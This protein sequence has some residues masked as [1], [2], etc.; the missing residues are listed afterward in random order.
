VWRE[1]RTQYNNQHRAASSQGTQS[2]SLRGAESD[3][4]ISDNQGIATLPSV[5]RNDNPIQVASIGSLNGILSSAIVQTIPPPTAADLTSTIEVQFTPAILAKA[6][7]LN[8]NP[9]QIYN[10]V[11]NNIEYTHIRL[12]PGCRHVPTNHAV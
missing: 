1:P 4:A 11:Y 8:H 5:A 7:E 6:A 10:W 9:V 12:N 2:L 3:E